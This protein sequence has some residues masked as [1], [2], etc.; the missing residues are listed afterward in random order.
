MKPVAEARGH[1]VERL[2]AAL[3][4][5]TRSGEGYRSSLGTETELHAYVQLQAA[6][7]EVAARQT[8]LDEMDAHPVN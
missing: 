7:E 6:S 5:Q 1:A 2:E 8:W 3:V 4:E